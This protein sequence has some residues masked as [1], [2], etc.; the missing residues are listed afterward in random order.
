MI[1]FSRENQVL[2]A[3]AIEEWGFLYHCMKAVPPDQ[4]LLVN[5]RQVPKWQGIQNLLTLGTVSET[6]DSNWQKIS[7]EVNFDCDRISPGNRILW[8]SRSHGSMVFALPPAGWKKALASL[9][10]MGFTEATLVGHLRSQ[11]AS[12]KVVLS[13]WQ[14]P[15]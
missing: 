9:R 4:Q 15:N 5:F 10:K 13:D 14:A 7:G 8:D 11:G 6:M 12:P 2:G 1:D 3:V